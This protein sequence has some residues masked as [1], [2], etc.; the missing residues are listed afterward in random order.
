MTDKP[1]AFRLKGPLKERFD[2]YASENSLNASRAA[3]TLIGI[4]LDV[5]AGIVR[6]A[7]DVGPPQIKRASELLREN[8]IPTSRVVKQTFVS[9][10]VTSASEEYHRRKEA[11]TAL[12]NR[13]K[14]EPKGKAK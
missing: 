10:P 2:A 6:K 11:Q 9:A 8:N 5:P 12:W 3:A 4:A 14:P 1:Y 7:A 13:M